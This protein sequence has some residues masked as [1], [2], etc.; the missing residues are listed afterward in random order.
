MQYW[1]PAVISFVITI[2]TYFV[3]KWFD[4]RREDKS[5][6]RKEKM[7]IFKALMAKRGAYFDYYKVEALNS[8]SVIFSDS[9]PVTDAWKAYHDALNISESLPVDERAAKQ[10]SANDKYIVLLEK[11]AHDLGYKDSVV[12]TDIKDSYMPIWIRDEANAR[13]A[14]NDL[15]I[16][17]A[18]NNK[19]QGGTK[20]D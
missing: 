2:V 5:E 1:L 19:S 3:T 10:A 6:K 4:N 9:K 12:W 7:A 8:I 13:L 16:Q 18:N 11:M 20:N 15:M 14:Y 17:L